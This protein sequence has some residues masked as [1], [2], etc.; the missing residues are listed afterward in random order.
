MPPL[1]SHRAR[2]KSSPPSAIIFDIGGVIV[3]VDTR[4]ALPLLHSKKSVSPEKIWAS[5]Q[6]DPLFKDWQE[7]RVS[8]RDWCAHLTQR[9]ALRITFDQ[10]CRAWTS[11][12]L[13][14]QILPD[15]LFARLSRR[16]RLVLMSNTDPL[17]VEFMLS[18]FT[19]F[20]YFPARIYSCR[21]G[22]SKPEPKIYK[23]AIHAAGASP[24][25]ILYIDDVI[26]YIRGGQRFGLDAVRFTSPRQLE[27]DLRQ[28]NLL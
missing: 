17:H 21:V 23:A 9:F 8:P 7:G 24:A 12:L 5:I 20:R 14:Q 13:P 18:H 25:Q 4:R 6:L 26:P 1:R 3:R 27:A 15:S 16:C 28:R 22:A 10:F 2:P 11:V 19:F